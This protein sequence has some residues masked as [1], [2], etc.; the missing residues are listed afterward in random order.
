NLDEGTLFTVMLPK[1]LTEEQ[2]TNALK[3]SVNNPKQLLETYR[4][5]GHKHALIVDLM[6]DALFR[7]PMLRAVD[8][9]ADTGAPVWVY[10]FTWPTPV[11]GGQLGATHALEIPFVW[12]S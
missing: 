10:Q 4:K 8:A 6:T 3:S 2:F 7:M 5:V 1:D 9:Q 12:N 11:F